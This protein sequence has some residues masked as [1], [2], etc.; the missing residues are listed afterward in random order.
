MSDETPAEKAEARAIRR[1]WISIGEAVAVAGVVIAG[2]TFW[3][4]YHDRRDA[5]ADTAATKAERSAQ[6]QRVPLTTTSADRGDIEFRG[7]AD[8]PL[9]AT[10][11]RFPAALGVETQTTVATHRIEADWLA[12]PMLK[13]TDGGADRRDGRVP[14]LIA[15]TCA[16]DDGDRRE[17]AIYDLVWRTEPGGLIGGRSFILRGLVRREAGGDQR[18]LDTIWSAIAPNSAG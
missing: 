17:V 9:Q 13:F 1:R 2:L 14:V 15:A 16:A 5:A 4:G 6:R 10:E 18:R 11:I 12:G 8:C 7:P 3:T